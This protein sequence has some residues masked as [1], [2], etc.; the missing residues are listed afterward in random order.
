MRQKLVAIITAFF[1]LLCANPVWAGVNLNV[2]GK[3]YVPLTAPQLT[4]GTT[5]VPLSFVGR[6]LG[7]EIN[8][9]DKIVTV[10]KGPNTLRLTLNDTKADLNGKQLV[11]PQAPTMVAGEVMV[12]LRFISEAFGATVTWEQNSQTAAVKY[13]EQRQGMSI[14]ELMVKSSEALLKN[15][16][17]KTDVKISMDMEMTNTAKQET[18]NSTTDMDMYMAVHQKPLFMYIRTTVDSPAVP[19]ARNLAIS[20]TTEAFINEEGMYIT[21]PGEEGWFKMNIPGM[22]MKAL[23]EQSNSSDPLAS[24]QMMQESGAIMSFGDDQ[25]RDGKSYWVINVIMGAESFNRLFQSVM[26]QMPTPSAT[27]NISQDMNQM[28]QTL[29]QNMKADIFYRVWVNQADLL[30]TFMDLEADVDLKIP[31]T[32]VGNE[33]SDPV[34]MCIIEKASYKIY[35]FGQPFDIP[36]VSQARDFNEYLQQQMTATQL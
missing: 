22:D 16:T 15:K 36:D 2:N 30:P 26:S 20:A 25:M 10:K 7:A 21:I 24:L 5:M 33:V 29:F 14:E 31:A 35:D 8:L 19:E 34:D 23:I 13:S 17:Y 6:V 18:V 3:S 28:M 12:P 4:K 32:K 11:M 9:T 27:N 1:L